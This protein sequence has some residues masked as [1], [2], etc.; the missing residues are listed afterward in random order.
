[1]EMFDLK[2]SREIGVLKEAVKEAILE[3]DIQNEYQAAYDF[4]I[5]RA[6]KLGLKKIEK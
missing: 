1:M 2:P 3:G 4:V 5:K 6:E